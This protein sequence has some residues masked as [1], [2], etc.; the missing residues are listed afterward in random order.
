[1]VEVAFLK[2]QPRHLMTVARWIHEEWTRAG[3]IDLDTQAHAMQGWL[4]DDRIPLCLVA[5][6]G[7]LCVGTVSIFVHD[8]VSR[9]DLTP[10]LAALYVDAA[11]RDRGIGGALVGRLVEVAGGLGIR[12][13]YLHTETA[14]G[15]YRRKG[16]RFL[17]RTVND[18]N[19]GSDVFDLDLAPFVPSAS[20]A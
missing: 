10:W 20:H 12:K 6:D 4:N 17:F 19:E 11:H 16:W 8:L 2:H 9:Q 15:Y 5:T 1:V 18:F 13:L 3:G 14:S 7:D